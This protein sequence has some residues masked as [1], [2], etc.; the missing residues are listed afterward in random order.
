MIMYVISQENCSLI[1]LIV[2]FQHQLPDPTAIDWKVAKNLLIT[3]IQRMTDVVTVQEEA[4]TVSGIFN[5]LDMLSVALAVLQ[6]SLP[7]SV[8]QVLLMKAELLAQFFNAVN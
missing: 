5:R 4:E 6:H 8:G 1:W 3:A 2:M 7:T